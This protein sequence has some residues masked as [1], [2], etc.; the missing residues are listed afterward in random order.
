VVSITG[1][2]R[3]KVIVVAVFA[4]TVTTVLA[5]VH[6]VITTCLFR[7]A[8]GINALDA[9]TIVVVLPDVAV[10]YIS[11]IIYLVVLSGVNPGVVR[12][13]VFAVL[14][15]ITIFPDPRPVPARIRTL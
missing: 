11:I 10:P 4:T 12:V 2:M 1:I 6:A 14:P 15:V 9:S 3:A 5:P 7:S 8:H 13:R